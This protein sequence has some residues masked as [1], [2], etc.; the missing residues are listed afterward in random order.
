MDELFPTAALSGLLDAAFQ[1]RE[2]LFSDPDSN[3][4]RMFNGFYEG[5]PAFSIDRY[6]ETAV[7]LWMS[8]KTIPGP[9]IETFLYKICLNRIP[10]ITGVLFKNR[11]SSIPEEKTGILLHGQEASRSVCEWGVSYPVNLQLNKDCGF[12]L[13]SSLLRRWLLRNAAGKRVLNTFAYTGSLGDAAAAGNALSVTQTDLNHNYLSTRH[14]SQEYIHGDFF[15]ITS[16]L[17]RAGRLFDLIILDPPFFAGTTRGGRVDLASDIAP[18]IN[19]I[20]PL[21]AHHGKIIAVNNALFLSGKD[22]LAQIESLCGPW[23]S[24]SEIIPVPESFFG[25]APIDKTSLPSDPTPF[26]HPTK[27]IVLDI[28]RKDER[29]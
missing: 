5:C 14:S 15:H 9:D 22:F 4:F 23:L 26:N 11:F 12:Y 17:R 27:I 24:V 25:F 29:V 21:A 1:K 18:L 3:A 28:L 10:G 19:K 20:R 16:S 2:F 7:I 6:A 8:K 13:D